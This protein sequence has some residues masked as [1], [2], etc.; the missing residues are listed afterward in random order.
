VEKKNRSHPSFEIPQLALRAPLPA[1]KYRRPRH[2]VT[3]WL[4]LSHCPRQYHWT[5][6]QPGYTESELQYEPKASAFE[7]LSASELGS[8]MHEVLEHWGR[9]ENAA[10]EKD[11]QDLADLAGPERLQIESVRDWI[12]K[13]SLMQ[14]AE[15]GVREVWT[16]LGFEVALPVPATPPEVLIGTMDRLVCE[17]KNGQPGVLA[18]RFQGDPCF[19][20]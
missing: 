5:Y 12:G 3:E 8:R 1:V 9:K 16:E 20:I 10:W 14:P 7:P 19:Q 2:S 17:L 15:V 18:H 6:L 4:V 11:L 13:S